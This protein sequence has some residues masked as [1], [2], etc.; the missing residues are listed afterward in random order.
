[1]NWSKA[2]DIGAAL[3]LSPLFGFTVAAGLLFLLKNFARDPRLFQP[4]PG[5]T[6][7]PLWIR[8]LLILTCSGVS[9]AHGNND[10]QKGVGLIMLILIGLMPGG[11]ALDLATA[12][13]EVAAART[14]T[15][16]IDEVLVAA[17]VLPAGAD[18][19][20]LDAA[21]NAQAQKA[22]RAEEGVLVALRRIERH[23]EGHARVS[24]L[25][26]DERFAVRQAVFLLED[27]LKKLEKAGKLG[28]L[29]K[30]QREALGA[31]RKIVQRLTDYAPF[32]VVLAVAIA[33]GTGTMVGW[34]RIVITVGEKIG[35]SHLTYA[36]GAA[37]E[38][39]AASTIWLSGQ[40]GLPVSTTHVL[41]SGIAGTMVAQKSGLQRSTVRNILLA[42][43]LTLPATV[44]LAGGLYLL[45]RL[46]V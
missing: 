28:A 6:P 31:K 20:A 21:M 8:T 26:R 14:A 29:T 3:L 35:K 27:G 41:S 17:R 39:V 40:L 23:L 18:V 32:W 2:G 42:W 45:L 7:P 37:A 5:L 1:V 36:Q 33:L 9:Y 16:Q 25:D 30:E 10:G 22:D 15:H 11:F 4:P 24:E 34:K 13:A 19:A 12:E 44:L 43:V 46:F 38:L